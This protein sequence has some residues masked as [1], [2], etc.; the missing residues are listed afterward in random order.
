MKHY[1]LST[2]CFVYNISDELSLDDNLK[3]LAIYNVLK[4]DELFLKENSIYDIVPTYNSIAFHFSS[5]DVLQIEK[6]ILDK[7]SQISHIEKATN[8]HIIEVD[9]SGLD[10]DRVCEYLAISKAELIKLHTQS[11]YH[12]AM[13]GFKPYFPYLLGMNERLQVPRLDKPRNRVA[14]G[15]I[16]I[17][18]LQT[19]IFPVETPSGWNIIG[20]TN[21]RD[22]KNFKAGDKIVFRE[23]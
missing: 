22:F 23:V 4:S 12:I 14:M 3:I 6:N 13:L 18:G 21:F 19:A 9:Y 1:F 5:L 11:E 8:T 20:Q 17:G 10:T 15:S 7:I 16:G 2:S